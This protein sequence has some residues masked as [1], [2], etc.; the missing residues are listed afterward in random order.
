MKLKDYTKEQI[1]EIVNK[2]FSVRQ[3]LIMLCLNAKG[4]NYVL[5]R[6]LIKDREIDTSHF[7]NTGRYD[8]NKFVSGRTLEDYILN[9]FPISSNSL[10]KKLLQAKLFEYKCYS[11]NISS[12]LD[13]PLPLELHHINGNHYDNSLCN[14]TLLCPNCHAQT[15]THKGRNKQIN[16]IKRQ[17]L[18]KRLEDA[19]PLLNNK[20][21]IKEP[22]QKLR[23][24]CKICKICS[25][26]FFTKNKTC[27]KLCGRLT[28]RK[29]AWENYD[30]EKLIAELK[31]LT[32]VG[33]FLGCSA[34]AVKKRIKKNNQK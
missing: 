2:C 24:S 17:E 13:K 34:N 8:N 29:I 3:V 31:S 15:D 30:L 16:F 25:K 7:K 33:K 19:L 4:S 9:K 32:Q 21:V 1:Q 22:K 26:E 27:S 6:K 12:W 28:T 23:K 10:R 20:P 11:C 5:I 18:K 14:L